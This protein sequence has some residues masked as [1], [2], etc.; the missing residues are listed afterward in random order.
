MIGAVSEHRLVDAAVMFQ[1]GLSIAKKIGPADPNFAGQ[2]GLE[3]TGGPQFVVRFQ[4]IGASVFARLAN[5]N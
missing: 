3:E 1:V 2:R 4:S 5:L